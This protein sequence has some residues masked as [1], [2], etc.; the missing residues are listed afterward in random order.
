MA[1]SQKSESAELAAR[2]R[3][4]HP[5]PSEHA[6]DPSARE[7]V[8]AFD[9][10]VP[11]E[12]L[13]RVVSDTSRVNRA[14]GLGEMHFEEREGTLHG[15][16]RSLGM[17]Q[18][19]VEIPWT[20]VDGSYLTSQRRY[21][22]GMA[23]SVYAVYHL[24]PTHDGAGTRFYVYFSWIPRGF[25]GLSLLRLAMAWLGRRYESVVD[26]LARSG[27]SMALPAPEPP[28]LSDA[29]RVRVDECRRALLARGLDPTS[30]ESLITLVTTGDELDLDRIAPLEIAHTLGVDERTLV[31]TCLHATRVGLLDMRWEVLCPHCR[32]VRA[33][34]NR[35][36]DL[37]STGRC[38]VCEIT[39]ATKSEQ[40]VAIS[41]R[42]HPTVRA[43]EQRFYCSAEPATKRHIELQ[44]A[45]APGERIAVPTRLSPGKHRIRIVGREDVGQLDVYDGRATEQPVGLSVDSLPVS[46]VTGPHPV[47]HL[48]GSAASPTRFVVETS[49]W[50]ERVLRPGRVLGMQGFRDLF[51]EEYLA[52]DV[53]LE[54]G[55]QTILF[56][57]IVGSTAF[58][59]THGDPAAF[60]IVKEHFDTLYSIVSA[61]HGAI[62]KTIGDATMAAFSDPV[63]ALEAALSMQR[64]FVDAAESRI[65]IRV[66]MH[67][68]P[69]IAV[70]FHQGIDYFGGTVN[71]AAK[72]QSLVGA[73]E[74][75]LSQHTLEAPRVRERLAECGLP[76]EDVEFRSSALPSPL[77]AK[78]MRIASNVGAVA[79]DARAIKA[80]ATPA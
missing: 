53:Q 12:A 69:C 19:W 67:T 10:P 75:V 37:P 8:F 55:E 34:V 70:Q 25:L 56:T 2:I 14:L 24:E 68:G 18:E 57:D 58:Y 22:R 52:A 71:L 31:E 77:P 21:S 1:T 41:F 17:A 20:W 39:F 6:G 42:P 32:G 59:A 33:S 3:A 9:V 26:A 61:H 62:V 16:S 43:I 66:S 48:E 38:D 13:F 65:S 46:L 51:A 47:L 72:L 7:W 30:V 74:I 49:A 79:D 45:L 15:R 4:L 5:P 60:A 11:P 29:G 35:L 63:D 27:R 23:R 76:V 54:V 50:S 44:I 64:A 28:T 73:G 40:V 78:R 36:G 80:A